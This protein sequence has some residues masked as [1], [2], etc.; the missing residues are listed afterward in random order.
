MLTQ[1]VKDTKIASIRPALKELVEVGSTLYSDEW[2][3]YKGSGKFYNHEIV[4]HKRRQFKNGD[5]CTNG[6]E[7][8]WSRLKRTLMGVY[9]RFSKKHLFRFINEFTFRFNTKDIEQHERLS[10]MMSNMN[11]PLKYKQL[12]AA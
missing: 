2:L 1:P 5:A 8:A 6:I 7:G 12:I 10:V 4:D 3:G 9:Y 11:R